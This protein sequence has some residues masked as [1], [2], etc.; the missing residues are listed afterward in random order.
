MSRRV[1][2]S[3]IAPQLKSRKFPP[4]TA[5]SLTDLFHETMSSLLRPPSV[6]DERTVLVDRDS[7]SS[8]GT[9]PLRVRVNL[10]NGARILVPVDGESTVTQLV[11]ESARRAI[12]LNLS[13][14][15]N[16]ATLRSDDGSVL[17]GEDSLKDVLDLA[18]NPNLFL[19]RVEAQS[20]LPSS[21]GQIRV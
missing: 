2:K 15:T 3:S 20:S 12:A 18:E 14:D 13:Y 19:G 11:A 10:S 7:S 5:L 8:L 1:Y 6:V 16:E 21:V 17:F 4:P 9:K